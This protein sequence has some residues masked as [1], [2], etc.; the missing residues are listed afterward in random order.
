MP[1]K[2]RYIKKRTYKKKR[3]PLSKPQIKAIKKINRKDQEVKHK[4]G[5]G[6]TTVNN[7]GTVVTLVWPSRGTAN[8]QRVGDNIYVRSMWIDYSFAV[9]DTYNLCRITIIQWYVNSTVTAPTAGAIYDAYGDYPVYAPFNPESKQ[10]FK[11]LY[12]KVHTVSS[13]GR[14]VVHRRLRLTRNFLRTLRITEDNVTSNCIW[15]GEIYA[16][17]S[18]DSSVTPSPAF[19]WTTRVNFT[20]A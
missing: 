19:V 1:Y 20:D 5:Q 13:N 4:L 9:A 3:Y 15:K 10:L 6:D 11:V 7:A 2:K 16:I 12:D 14:E 18:S 17:L 8:D